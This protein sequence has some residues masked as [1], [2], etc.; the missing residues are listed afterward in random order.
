MFPSSKLF[1][2][3][4]F[5]GLVSAKCSYYILSVSFFV[6][7]PEFPVLRS[8]LRNYIER[9]S[10]IV[11]MCPSPYFWCLIGIRRGNWVGEKIGKSE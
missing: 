4:T 7:A 2:A 6:W 9:F 5:S 8:V 1:S 11:Q 3:K 10:I